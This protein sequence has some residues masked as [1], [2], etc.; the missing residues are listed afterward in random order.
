MWVDQG[1]GRLGG[2]DKRQPHHAIG[3]AALGAVGATALAEGIECAAARA[4]RGVLLGLLGALLFALSP[5][6]V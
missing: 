3:H 4:L 6:I 1:V 2:G 5:D